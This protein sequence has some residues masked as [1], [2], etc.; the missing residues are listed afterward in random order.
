IRKLP[1]DLKERPLVIFCTGGIRCEKAGPLLQQQG[2]RDIWQLD[3]GILKYFEQ[4]GGAHYDGECFVFDQRVALDAQLR[5][6]NTTQCYACQQPV[7]A[8]DQQSAQY[9][10]G[11]S[12]PSCYQDPAE[13][14]RR[15][16]E[17]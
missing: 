1:A 5:E 7:T 4:C 2:F 13:Q 16:L 10:P 15:T 14:L 11:Q 12:C 8:Q 9:V 3:G 6:T 17:Q